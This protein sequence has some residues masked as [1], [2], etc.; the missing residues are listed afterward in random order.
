MHDLH[1]AGLT[2]SQ[3]TNHIDVD[4]RHFLQVQDK[5]GPIALEL[6]F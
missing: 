4:D 5:Q 3:E 6:V 2:L 1:S